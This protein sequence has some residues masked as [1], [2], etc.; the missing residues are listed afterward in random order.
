MGYGLVLYI[1]QFE[2]EGKQFVWA[3][4]PWCVQFYMQLEWLL[5]TKWLQVYKFFSSLILSHTHLGGQIRFVCH[6]L[7]KA[8]DWSQRYLPIQWTLLVKLNSL[9]IIIW[10]C[11][12]WAITI[13]F[14]HWVQMYDIHKFE[15]RIDTNWSIWVDYLFMLLCLL[16]AAS[17]ATVPWQQ[18]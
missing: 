15:K 17:M 7:G 2:T 13:K 11:I 6:G 9:C 1:H 3:H 18:S 12:Q 5:V 8:D 16:T 4:L 14:D 10:M